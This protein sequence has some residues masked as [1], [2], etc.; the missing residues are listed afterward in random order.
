MSM[1]KPFKGPKPKFPPKGK[2]AAK[3]NL[4]VK[5]T[6]KVVEDLELFYMQTGEMTI[7]EFAEI[8]KADCGQKIEL[9]EEMGVMEWI[10]EAGHSIDIERM[11]MEDFS[12]EEDQGFLSAYQ[13]QQ[14]YAVTGIDT[15]LPLIEKCF[16]KVAAKGGGFLCY[17]TED[18]QPIIEL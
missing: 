14:I 5:E 17:D 6:K 15:D 11:S 9:W 3:P 4:E 18:F 13:V 16:V 7:A 1:K 8:L 2:P 10:T 12:A